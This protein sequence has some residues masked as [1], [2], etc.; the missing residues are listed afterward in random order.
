MMLIT[1]S[2]G[3]SVKETGAA[4]QAAAVANK[5]G[6]LQ[7]HNLQETM[8]KKGVEFT[9]E[10][11]IHEVCNPHFSKLVLEANMSIS[12]ILPCR[13]SVYEEGGRTYLSTMKPSIMLTMFDVPELQSTVQEVEDTLAR[14]MREA[15]SG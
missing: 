8:A 15:G 1:M 3:K 14:I 5:F 12:T 4:L 9:R 2:T 10:C 13:I 6:V 11:L 7:V